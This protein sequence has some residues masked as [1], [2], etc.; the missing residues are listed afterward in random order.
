MRMPLSVI[1]LLALAVLKP[2]GLRGD[3]P[4][5][6]VAQDE[7]SRRDV[8]LR[9]V[10]LREVVVESYGVRVQVPTAW[11]VIGESHDER[12]FLAQTAESGA[13]DVCYLAC[14]LGIAPAG[15]E[16]FQS[17]HQAADKREQQRESPRRTLA[18]SDLY[19]W[20][21][22]PVDMPPD[23]ERERLDCEWAFAPRGGAPAVIERRSYLVRNGS[24]YTFVLT[25]PEVAFA[26]NEKN[27]EAMVRSARFTP[28]D[29][30]LQRL[31][32]G[33]WMQR[34]YRFAMK[35]PEDWR[36]AF[37]PND[38]ALFF[39]TGPTQEVFTDNLIV[40]ASP[41]R[42]LN[43]KKIQQTFPDQLRKEDD[44]IEIEHCEIVRQDGVEVLETLIHTKR[45][46]FEI[47]ILE[48]R[49]E[50]ERRNYEVKF[51]CTTAEFRKHR[52]ALYEA[53]DTF[54]ELAAGD[55]KPTDL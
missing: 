55:A 34:E 36:P 29:T 38:H 41:S 39:A 26:A 16:E 23:E 46:P 49:F 52:E 14:E 43:L 3:E 2:V 48:R 27:F 53:L 31:P 44:A 5:A 1:V 54:R 9:E 4:A 42:R 15:L 13:A 10:P 12:A 33:Y 35:L 19:V 45:G 8:P 18:S 22:V 51:T 17:R 6:D 32:D 28:A 21:A 11:Q 50:G 37:A 24:L 40:L 7:Q 25:G 47:S 20:A 30:G